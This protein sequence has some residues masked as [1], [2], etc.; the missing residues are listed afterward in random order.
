MGQDCPG[1]TGSWCQERTGSW[2]QERTDSWCQE[3]TGS[4]CLL[5]WSGRS[6]QG[7]RRGGG[8]ELMVTVLH[9]A[10]W[11]LHTTILAAY[12]MLLKG[13]AVHTFT[14]P[15]F[16]KEIGSEWQLKI[17]KYLKKSKFTPKSTWKRKKI[18][19]NKNVTSL[20]QA[21][22]FPYWSR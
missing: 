15:L 2:C 11:S 18:L 13:Q 10:Q 8:G 9:R 20:H 14:L 3:R 16:F 5:P 6:H 17:K 7:S 4:W 12:W 22:L 21:F 1:R 19:D